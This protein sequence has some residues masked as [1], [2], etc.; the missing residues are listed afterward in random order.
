MQNYQ[1][2]FSLRLKGIWCLQNLLQILT[3]L[4]LLP[5]SLES[6]IEEVEAEEK[7]ERPE[8]K[9]EELPPE[10]WHLVF[11]RVPLLDLVTSGPLVCRRWNE[12]IN[13]ENVCAM[14]L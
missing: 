9:W 7:K 13:D 10:V 14:F 12:I 8:A 5:M 11:Q 4:L 6:F 2:S 3:V 1:A